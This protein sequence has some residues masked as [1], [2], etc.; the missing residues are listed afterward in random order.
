MGIRVQ[1]PANIPKNTIITI[2]AKKM[3][4]TTNGAIHKLIFGFARSENLRLFLY[5]EHVATAKDPTLTRAVC[6]DSIVISS[7]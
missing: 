6:T 1:F 7:V 3:K 4:P 2:T 5:S